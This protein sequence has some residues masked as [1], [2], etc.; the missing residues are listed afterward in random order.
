[1]N[2]TTPRLGGYTLTC[3]L[4]ALSIRLSLDR[5]EE[6]ATPQNYTHAHTICKSTIKTMNV[7]KMIVI[8]PLLRRNTDLGLN[9]HPITYWLIKICFRLRILIRFKELR[10][11]S[12]S[13]IVFCKTEHWSLEYRNKA[14]FCGVICNI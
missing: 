9:G 6:C 3:K 4:Y 5:L 14:I 10:N 8:L 12:V 11:C 1:M 7:F 13:K 2:T